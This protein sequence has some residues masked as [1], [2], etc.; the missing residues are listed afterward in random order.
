M[1]GQSNIYLGFTSWQKKTSQKGR[2]F[3]SG[4]WEPGWW[5]GKT[6]DNQKSEFGFYLSIFKILQKFLELS[7]AHGLT[8]TMEILTASLWRTWICKV[9]STGPG[10]FAS[11]CVLAH[12]ELWQTTLG[13][14]DPRGSYFLL[15]SACDPAVIQLVTSCPR[16]FW[17]YP[18]TVLAFLLE[19]GL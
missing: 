9:L 6:L 13:F 4:E 11:M 8:Q 3:H 14:W 1:D 12:T 16:S 10:D 15:L 19:F 17:F 5:G 18:D 7:E 2:T